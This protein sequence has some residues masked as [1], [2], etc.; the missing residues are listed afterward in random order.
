M[1]SGGSLNFYF[2]LQYYSIQF[3]QHIHIRRN[4]WDLL[5][6]FKGRCLSFAT[7]Q[8][9]MIVWQVRRWLHGWPGP[10]GRREETRHPPSSGGEGRAWTPS[11][12]GYHKVTCPWGFFLLGPDSTVIFLKIIESP[13][14]LL[15]SRVWL[16]LSQ[17]LYLAK[18]T[19]FFS[20]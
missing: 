1:N 16:C 19:S 3:S 20:G 17:I 12:L 5:F 14:G 2:H 10:A 11:T 7:T 6:L 9:S 15:D 13:E 18:K 8:N 4:K